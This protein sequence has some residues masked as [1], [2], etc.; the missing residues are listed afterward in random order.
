[1][2]AQVTQDG[3][4]PLGRT[5][6]QV[7]AVSLGAS[8]LGQDRP[9]G[10][11]PS[12]QAAETAR[13]ML[14]GPFRLVDSSNSYGQGRSEAA[15][16]AGLAALGGTL[17]EGQLLATKADRDLTT[18]AFD[19]DRVLRSFEESTR[20]TG[21]DHFPL[22]QLHDPYTVSFADA[23]GPGGAVSA[24][25]RLRDEGAVGHLGIAAGPL[26]LVDAYVGTGVFDVVLTHNRYTLLNRS[27]ADL[28]DAWAERGLG[29]LNGAAFGGGL[30]ARGPRPGSTYAYEPA[31]AEVLGF[32]ERLD[33]V[34][35]EWDVPLPA[36][37]L[38]FSLRNPS[39]STTLVGTSVPGR[40]EQTR[41]LAE[42]VIPDGFWDAVEQLGTP[43]V[44]FG[45]D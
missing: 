20:R 44:D 40:V 42:R 38:Q 25:V 18:G 5:G 35:R 32:V 13:V 11:P 10:E 8:T 12:E 6:L 43:P 45:E 31:P 26:S 23:M 19:H 41:V 1:M 36:A 3:L 34:C 7:S 28:I 14:T 33:A 27:A 21:L 15:L 22:Y 30:L 2:Q 37:A 39:V 16:G 24:L 4:R 29:V 17:P 9:Q